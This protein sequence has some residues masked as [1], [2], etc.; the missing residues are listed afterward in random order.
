VRASRNAP[1]SGAVV[2][3]TPARNVGRAD[4]QESVRLGS[5]TNG[6]GTKDRVVLPTY[7]ARCM[8]CG[9]GDGM[10]LNFK[11]TMC[12]NLNRAE[13]EQAAAAQVAAG[14]KIGPKAVAKVMADAHLRMQ[15]IMLCSATDHSK[16]WV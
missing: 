13:P 4:A 10:T 3:I 7:C 12:V 16:N 1:A 6:N 11:G 8:T 15:R 14:I 9:L 2:A 5:L